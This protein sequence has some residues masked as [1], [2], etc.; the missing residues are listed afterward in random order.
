MLPNSQGVPGLPPALPV[1]PALRGQ[2]DSDDSAP[3]HTAAG[4]GAALSRS[5]A[6]L[7]GHGSRRDDHTRPSERQREAYWPGL[8]Y[9][10][11]AP[12]NG[13]TP[14]SWEEVEVGLVMGALQ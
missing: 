4:E 5:P 9:G 7:D 1:V 11:R 10:V 6:R 14:L 8:R 12:A 13:E 3:V 2:A